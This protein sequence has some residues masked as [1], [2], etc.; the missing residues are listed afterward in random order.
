[1]NFEIKNIINE[2]DLEIK[3]LNYQ[4]HSIDKLNLNILTKN[5][6]KKLNSFKSKKRK[7]EFFFTRILWQKFGK[8]ITIEYNENGK[9]ILSMGYISISHSKN[10]IAIGFSD[11]EKIGLDIEHY[12]SKINRIKEKFLSRQELDSFD[13]TNTETITTLWSVKEATYKLVDIPGLSYKDSIKV[14]DIGEINRVQLIT[15]NKST[16][17]SFRR[18][19]FKDFILTHCDSSQS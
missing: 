4:N 3:L 11:K 14:T 18:I 8:G 9:P 6:L 17:F 12:N 7:L 5:E 2:N 16:F 13:L 19:V 10:T 15:K 1:L